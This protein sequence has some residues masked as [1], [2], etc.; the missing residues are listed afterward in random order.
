MRIL[1]LLYLVPVFVL[2]ACD[3][4]KKDSLSFSCKRM[5]GCNLFLLAI[6]D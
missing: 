2:V 4:G 5:Y 3:S 6:I 1:T